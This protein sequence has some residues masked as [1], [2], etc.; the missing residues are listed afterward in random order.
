MYTKFSLEYLHQVES[1]LKI[2]IL[3][4]FLYKNFLCTSELSKKPIKIF[5]LNKKISFYTSESSWKPDT[6]S[7][8]V[9]IVFLR[10]TIVWWTSISGLFIVLFISFTKIPMKSITLD[11]HLPFPDSVR[12][13]FLV[14]PLLKKSTRVLNDFPSWRLQWMTVLSMLI[15]GITAGDKFPSCEYNMWWRT[16]QNEDSTLNPNLPGGGGP[17]WPPLSFF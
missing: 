13:I 2:Y 4:L 10:F 5:L 11:P 14:Q 17:L 9:F 12:G 1:Q 15:R 8:P 16:R 6:R 3:Y 7:I